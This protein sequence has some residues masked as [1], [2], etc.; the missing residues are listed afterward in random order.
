MRNTLFIIIAASTIVAC[1]KD[2]FAQA[3]SVAAPVSD[4]PTVVSPQ[5]ANLPANH[6]PT[7]G[8]ALPMAQ[9]AGE[10][11][12]ASAS[13]FGTTG[14]LRWTAPATWTAAVPASSMRLAEYTLPPA[15]GSLPGE[16]SI[17]YFGASGGGGVEANVQRWIGQF[18]G[19]DG[20]PAASN[21]SEETVNGMKVHRV[22]ASGTYNPGMAGNGVSREN[23][24]MLGA[25]V[26]SPVGLYFSSSSAPRIPSR[27]DRRS[28]NR[29]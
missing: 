7:G 18:S 9:A 15:D 12:F 13:E 23:H 11:K 25:I 19:A 21:Q 5:P 16:I 10:V 27:R 3:P 26:E 2:E 6:P 1:Q 4:K 24:R 17:F 22:D 14:P 29:L 8:Q 28:L 20:A